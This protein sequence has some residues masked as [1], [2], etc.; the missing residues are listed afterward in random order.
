MH[1]FVIKQSLHSKTSVLS[2]KCVNM[3]P[4]DPTWD[5]EEFVLTGD[6][7]D[8]KGQPKTE[9]VQ[10]W[11][12]DPVECIKE[13]IGNPAFREKLRCSP[14]RAYEDDKGKSHIFDEMWSGDWWWNLQV[15]TLLFIFVAIVYLGLTSDYFR[16]SFEKQVT[17][18]QPFR[19]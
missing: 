16:T 1:R 14:Q 18:G 4:Q 6:E 8:D 5:C 17:M 15:S 2:H 12:Q 7:Q 11:K 19:Q 9:I 13:L 10:L 3:L